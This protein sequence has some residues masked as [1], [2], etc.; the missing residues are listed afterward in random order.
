MTRLP[1]ARLAFTPIE[2][3]ILGFEAAGARAAGAGGKIESFKAKAKPPPSIDR[4]VE[5]EV[6]LWLSMR[7]GS[8]Y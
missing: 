5:E 2:G 7:T 1:R 4:S 6:V 8:A 3:F